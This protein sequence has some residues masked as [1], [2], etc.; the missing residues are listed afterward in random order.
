MMQELDE[1]D[2]DDRQISAL[3]QAL[4]IEEMIEES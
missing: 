1:E 4:R 2:E 3:G